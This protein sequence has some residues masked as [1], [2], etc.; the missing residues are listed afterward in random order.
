MNPS[1]EP[2]VSS[3]APNQDLEGHGCSLHLQSQ[4][5]EPQLVKRG[6]PQTSGPIQIKSK[7]THPSQ[8]PPVSSEATNQDFKNMDFH[9]TLKIKIEDNNS[10]HGSTK[11]Q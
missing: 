5:R 6:V 9:G 11:D 1:W 4:D 7:M 10:D 2:P 3:K 8:D